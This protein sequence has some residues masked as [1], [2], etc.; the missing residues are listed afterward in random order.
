MVHDSLTDQQSRV[1]PQHAN[2]Q[3][4][5]YTYSPMRKTAKTP[6]SNYTRG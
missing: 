1:Q 4:D 2:S 5:K 3:K 6:N